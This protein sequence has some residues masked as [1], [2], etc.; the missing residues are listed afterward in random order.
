MPCQLAITSVSLGRGT[1]GHNFVHKMDMA[2]KHGY[3]GVELF[4][5]D[6][7]SITRMMPGGL[8]KANELEAARIIHQPFWHYEGLL[9]RSKHF[10]HVEKLFFWFKLAR[11]LETDMIQIPSNF[12]PKSQLSSDPRLAIQ[13]LQKVADFGLL[14][15]P[16][17]RFVYEAL[18]WGTHCDT[19]E[20]SW[21]IVQQVDRPNFGL[22]LDTFNIAARVWADPTDPTGRNKDSDELLAQSLALMAE[23]VDVSKVFCVQVVDAERLASP[24]LPGHEFHDE[25]QPPRMSW[26]RNCRL[27]YGESD[28]GACLPVKQIARVIFK[29]LGYQGW[30]S[31]ELFHRRMAEEDAT[32]PRELAARGAVA[33]KKL[34]RDVGVKVALPPTGDLA[35]SSEKRRTRSRR[36]F[37][38]PQQPQMYLG[39]SLGSLCTG[40]SHASGLK[41]P[42]K[43]WTRGP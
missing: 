21:E 36:H 32:V 33:W 15:E 20:R 1:A 10:E 23:I 6:L 37:L 22:C 28:R 25:A 4:H 42:Y 7:A 41:W 3:K 24:L 26:S 11:A 14:Q 31:M 17:M 12:L 38:R 40:P 30:V 5:D 34:V 29:D 27:F 9:D 13:D 39:E 35:A 2:Q 19:W 8:T 43:N 16:P 18:A